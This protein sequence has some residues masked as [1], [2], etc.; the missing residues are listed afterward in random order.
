ML[1]I[2]LSFSCKEKVAP[3]SE[4]IAKVWQPRIVLEGS[5]TV[6]SRGQTNNVKPGYTNYR[7]NLSSAP[8]VT[9]TDVDGTTFTGTYSLNDAGTQL[10]LTGLG[11]TA[12]TGTDGTLVYSITS[13]EGDELKLTLNQAFAKTGG[14]INTYTLVN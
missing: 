6:F 5:T 12:P 4:R 7:L 13:F 3:V 9:L 1:F 11:P 14:T 10:T 8:N 2:T